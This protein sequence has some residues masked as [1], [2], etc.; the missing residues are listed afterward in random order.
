MSN[1]FLIT[2]EYMKY[3]HFVL[4]GVSAQAENDDTTVTTFT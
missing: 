1:F 3:M 2:D 4:P